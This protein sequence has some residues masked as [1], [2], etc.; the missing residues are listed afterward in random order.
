MEYFLHVC[1]CVCVSAGHLH[2]YIS[3][4]SVW[5]SNIMPN[6]PPSI[7]YN[8]KGEILINNICINDL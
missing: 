5:I 2:L 6:N 4:I 8:C 7:M 3:R 1:V